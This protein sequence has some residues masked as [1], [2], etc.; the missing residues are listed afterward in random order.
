MMGVVVLGYF[1]AISPHIVIP[2]IVR[3][4]GVYWLA[5]S[6]LAMLYLGQSFLA[7]M[8]DGWPIIGTLIMSIASM[9]LLMT[10]G[11]ILGIIYRERR[12]QMNW[13]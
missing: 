8:L 5:V 10:N 2:A 6:V 4:G 13:I 3:A 9:Y 7:G 12:E 1:G 11:R